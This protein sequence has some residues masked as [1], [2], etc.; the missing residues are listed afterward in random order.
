MGWSHL[1]CFAYVVCSYKT[2][3]NI[4]YHFIKLC[5]LSTYDRS[6]LNWGVYNL[7]DFFPQM[8]HFLTDMSNRI[9]HQ[10]LNQVAV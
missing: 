10:K 8:E 1:L 3:S 9:E 5:L 7:H 6:G 2:Y 4:S